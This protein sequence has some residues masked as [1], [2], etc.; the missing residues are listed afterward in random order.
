MS[1]HLVGLVLPALAPQ[2]G[3]PGGAAHAYHQPY[4]VEQAVGWQRQIQRRDAVAAHTGGNKI[5]I[6]QNI[7]GQPRHAQH[8][9]GYVPGKLAENC[10]FLIHARSLLSHDKSA[11]NPPRGRGPRRQGRLPF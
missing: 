8:V 7:A 11:V 1:E 6:R 3:I 5:G 4:A 10:S 2:N 9:Q